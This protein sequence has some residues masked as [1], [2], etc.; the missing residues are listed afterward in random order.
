MDIS[1][2]SARCFAAYAVGRLSLNGLV[3]RLEEL[4]DAAGERP[5]EW[6]DKFFKAWSALEEV[7]AA[8][9][10]ESRTEKSFN[11]LEQRIVAGAI[12]ELRS[13]LELD[14]G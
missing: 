5:D 9:L 3:S 10:Q 4:R 6:H 14:A 7:N 1:V 11:P 2:E 13:L 8:V 12:T